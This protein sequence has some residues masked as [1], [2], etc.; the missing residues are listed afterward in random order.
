MTLKEN[1]FWVA[2]FYNASICILAFAPDGRVLTAEMTASHPGALLTRLM[3]PQAVKQMLTHWQQQYQLRRFTNDPKLARDM[4]IRALENLKKSSAQFIGLEKP[5][6]STDL[7]VTFDLLEKKSSYT[8]KM[9]ECRCPNCHEP[10]SAASG[11]NVDPRPGDISICACCASINQYG[12]KLDLV[13]LPAS[14]L[15][16]L[17]KSKLWPQVEYAVQLIKLRGGPAKR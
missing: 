14:D 5:E 6:A 8:R 10:I 4:A 15:T 1:D 16:R 12:K 3:V 2:E 7:S 17:K 11:N 9:P 13:A